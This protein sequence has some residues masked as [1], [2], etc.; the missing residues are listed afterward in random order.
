M[1]FDEEYSLESFY[2]EIMHCKAKKYE[3]LRDHKMGD[4]KRTCM[5]TKNQFVS[6]HEYHKFIQRLGGEAI[7][8]DKVLDNGSGYRLWVGRFREFLK[9]TNT[10]EMETFEFFKEKLLNGKYGDLENVMYKFMVDKGKL[11]EYEDD[12]TEAYKKAKILG[13]FEYKKS[14]KPWKELMSYI[15]DKRQ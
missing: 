13:A 4:Y 10:D 11:E 8:Q 3:V 9:V 7:H 1:T 14:D 5:E 12:K 6:R 15:T 2:H